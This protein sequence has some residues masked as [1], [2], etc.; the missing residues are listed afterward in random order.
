MYIYCIQGNVHPRFIFT[1]FAAHSLSD[2]KFKTE[3]IP[4]LKLSLNND[5]FSAQ[6][7]DGRYFFKGENDTGRILYMLISFD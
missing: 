6:I 7:Q 1:P 5:N 2:G 4:C 3:R